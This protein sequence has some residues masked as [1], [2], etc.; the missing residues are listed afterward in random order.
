[1]FK[2]SVALIA[3]CAFGIVFTVFWGLRIEPRFHQLLPGPEVVAPLPSIQAGVR[4]TI[5][6]LT[7]LDRWRDGPLLINLARPWPDG[8]VVLNDI[9]GRL[10]LVD[11][12]SP[13]GRPLLRV[14]T[15]LAGRFLQRGAEV[16][17]LSFA[18]HPDFRRSGAFGF[19]KLYTI[20]SEQPGTRSSSSGQYFG[21]SDRPADHLSVVSEWSFTSGRSLE[22]DPNSRRTLLVIEQPFLDHNAYYVDFRPGT[23]P[24]QPDHGNL[25]VGV[26]NGGRYSTLERDRSLIYGTIL[27]INP[28]ASSDGSSY[29]I[30]PD[31][32]FTDG[33]R[34]PEVWAEGFRNPQHFSWGPG[35]K[36][37]AIDIGEAHIEEVNIVEPGKHYGWSYLEGTFPLMLASRERIKRSYLPL[38]LSPTTLPVAQYDH[39]EGRAI[40]SGFVYQG[41]LLPALQ[42]QF[43]LGDLSNGRIFYFDPSSGKPPHQLRELILLDANGRPLELQTLFG[44]DRAD[45]RLA[46]DE[47]GEILL[48]NKHDD[49]IRRITACSNSC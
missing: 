27:R 24:G 35:G 5:E 37:F 13:K 7:K 32:P 39:S 48:L 14:D 45:L 49:T 41:T 23:L 44:A 21:L 20:H 31:N 30:P 16:G 15:I 19:R 10:L 4:G 43:V 26:G 38:F 29:V 9:S 40:G 3:A 18:F 33:E 6:V 1:M 28:E 11:T 25:Y 34:R 17:L 47:D 42:G 8:G 12:Q 22:I 46:P 2:K 36:L